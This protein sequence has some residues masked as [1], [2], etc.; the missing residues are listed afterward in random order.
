MERVTDLVSIAPDGTGGSG[1]A[2]AVGFPGTS[3][4]DLPGGGVSVFHYHPADGRTLVA[5]HHPAVGRAGAPVPPGNAEVVSPRAACGRF[6]PGSA[7]LG[8][9]RA[10]HYGSFWKAWARIVG[11]LLSPAPS[12]PVPCWWGPPR[13][14]PGGLVGTEGAMGRV[15]ATVGRGT[16]RGPPPAPLLVRVATL[17]FAVGVGLIALAWL[18]RLKTETSCERRRCPGK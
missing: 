2:A 11:L 10:W 9:Q 5:A 1:I 4:R 12:T 7:V 18:H 14:L 8:Q 3:Y 15:T 16:G 13:T 6:G 17:W